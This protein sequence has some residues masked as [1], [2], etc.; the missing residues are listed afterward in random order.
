MVDLKLQSRIALVTGG[1]LGI[2]AASTVTIDGGPSLEIG[3]GA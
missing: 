1:E 2:G 3:Q